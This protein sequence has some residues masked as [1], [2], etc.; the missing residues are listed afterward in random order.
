MPFNSYSCCMASEKPLRKYLS[1][2]RV[3]ALAAPYTPKRKPRVKAKTRP[4]M[5]E[6]LMPIFPERPVQLWSKARELVQQPIKVPEGRRLG[7][8]LASNAA[9]IR[10]LRN[11]SMLSVA[12]KQSVKYAGKAT[13]WQNPYAKPRPRA[14]IKMSSVWYTAY[15][16][17]LITKGNDSILATLGQDNLWQA[18]QD[19]GITGLHTGPMKYAGGIDGWK[20][21]PSVDGHFD[22]ISNKIDRLFGT[23]TEYRRLADAAHRHGGLVI[24]DL[25]PGHTGKGFDFRLAEMAYK[26][27]PGI[28]HMIEIPKH[29]WHLLPDIPDGQDAVNLS[30]EAEHQLQKRKY[31]IG[32][33]Q[34][35][36]MYEP[37]IKETNWSATPVIKGVDGIKRRW[38]YLH[39]WKQGQPSINWLDPSFA[40]M[41]LVIGDALHAIDQLGARGLRLDANGLLGL[42]KSED[43]RP[44]WSEGH[45]LSEAANHL[46][47]GSVRKVGGFTFQE[48]NVQLDDMKIM[49]N[50]GA[51]LSYDFVTRPGYH[52]A[53]ATGDVSFLRLMMLEARKYGIEPVSQVHALQNHDELTTE[54]VHFLTMHKDEAFDYHGR[55]LP[56]LQLRELV[57]KE[58]RD[59]VIHL[60]APYNLAYRDDAGIAC[61]T[62]S[63]VVATMGVKQYTDIDDNT[64]ATARQMHLLL[65]MFNA[66]QPGVFAISGWDL[67]GALTLDPSSVGS[68]VED[69]DTRWINRGSYDIMGVNPEADA[70]LSGMPKAPCLYDSLPEQLADPESFA[71]QLKRM[72]AVR[73]KQS[74]A[75][76]KQLDIPIL[77]NHAVLALVHQ[78]PADGGVQAT[79]LNFSNK[80]TTA[81]IT[82]E[83]FPAHTTA[84]D[85]FTGQQYGQVDP[86]G[87]IK[88]T[89]E[90]YQGMSLQFV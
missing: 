49:A 52:H 17:S 58:L 40:G 6:L 37:G 89:L 88:L 14:A 26:T 8:A 9:Y 67:V 76:A 80:P 29:D 32:K 79:V 12:E 46:I 63:V 65:A 69:G 30:P 47:A 43:D 25:I 16:A 3:K 33:L 38:V 68:L 15:P 34:R 51:D 70:S 31:I 74:L 60:E 81:T 39:Y 35:V 55:T 19:I 2:E 48:L 1:Y 84:T 82:S 28:Y 85:M 22:R 18:F 42:E 44:A 11:N 72:L 77:S 13:M 4:T 75:L 23:E 45:P 53:L 56:G 66:L 86:K 78:L 71:S 20:F 54:L 61:T 27:Y 41:K 5:T 21:T 10:W 50:S 83:H 57:Q 90:P 24:D 62:A 87:T 73:E 64:I 59:K 36:L 7:P